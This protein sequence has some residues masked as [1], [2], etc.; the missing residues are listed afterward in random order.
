LNY[1][2]DLPNSATIVGQ[3]I[4]DWQTLVTGVLALGAAYW[5]SRQIGQQINQAEKFHQSEISRRHAAV[6]C[7]LPLAL[8][9]I[10]GLLERMANSVAEEIE[11]RIPDAEA[12]A[13]G[14][15]GVDTSDRLKFEPINLPSDQMNVVRDFVETLTDPSEVK[16]VAELMAQLQVLQARYNAFDFSQP[17]VNQGLNYLLIDIAVAGALNDSIFNYARAVDEGSFGIVG[18]ISNHDAW[19]MVQQKLNG[20]VFLRPRLD[21]FVPARTR[22]KR[23]KEDN[24]SPWLER[25][26]A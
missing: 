14:R 24:E 11:Q 3:W 10:S 6:R 2:L 18:Q 26:E 1:C 4:Y 8:S 21:I 9:E 19:D 12:E 5:A 7:V 16:H 15:N 13:G 22:I 23:D 17:G 20:L 25:F